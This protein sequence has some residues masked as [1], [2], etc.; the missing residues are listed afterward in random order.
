MIIKHIEDINIRNLKMVMNAMHYEKLKK[1]KNICELDILDNIKIIYRMSEDK[2]I[3]LD[4]KLIDMIL[5]LLDG[6]Q[7]WLE[8]LEPTECSIEDQ[9]YCNE[10]KMGCE[11][12]YY[13]KGE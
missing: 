7:E 13:K 10:E 12:C 2:E 1:L 4:D 3:T 11:G 6:Y 5:D 8:E 9:L